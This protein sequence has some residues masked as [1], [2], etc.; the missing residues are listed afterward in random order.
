MSGTIYVAKAP[1]GTFLAN[2]VDLPGCIARGATREEAVER[3]RANF[4]DYVELL[5]SRGVDLEHVSG[6]DPA[7]FVVKEPE[8]RHT[9][10]EDFRGMREHELRDFLHQFEASRSA[11]LALVRGLSQ[12]QLE[13]KPSPDDWSIRECLEHIAESEV[14]FL[15]RLEP[16]PTGDFAT[17]QAAHRMAFQRFSVMD[18]EDAKGEHRIMG[19]RWSARKVARRLLEHEYEHLQQVREVLAALKPEAKA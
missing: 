6:L 18:A 2:V 4:G 3:V 5:R 9:Y 16:W 14:T 7:T 19:N 12:E 13:T 15:S 8:A 1:D 10:P 11:L 17:L